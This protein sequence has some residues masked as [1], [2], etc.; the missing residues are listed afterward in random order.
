[1]QHDDQWQRLASILARHIELIGSGSSLIAEGFRK[2][3]TALGPWN[4]WRSRFYQSARTGLKSGRGDVVEETPHRVGQLHPDG[5]FGPNVRGAGHFDSFGHQINRRR[6][7]CATG[8]VICGPPTLEHAL[9]Q[10]R[11]VH[12]ATRSG[13][14]ACFTQAGVQSVV[15]LNFPFADGLD[16]GLALVLDATQLSNTVGQ[17]GFYS[18]TGV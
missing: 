9:Q 15:H 5:S 16:R 8:G 10:C 3:L 4:L 6:R 13:Q 11:R 1:V 17:S 7:A 12:E 2:E 14:P 18:R